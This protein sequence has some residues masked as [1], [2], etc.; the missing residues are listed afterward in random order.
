MHFDDESVRPDCDA[1]VPERDQAAPSGS[2]A[3]IKSRTGG[4]FRPGPPPR[5]I[6]GVARDGFKVRI[7]RSHNIVGAVRDDVLGHISSSLT[8]ALSRA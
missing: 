4:S 2:M 8:V 6:A 3:R 5:D 1:R 7:P